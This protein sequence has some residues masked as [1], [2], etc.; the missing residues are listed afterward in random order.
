M[1]Y[2]LPV[3]VAFM[4]SFG[5]ANAEMAAPAPKAAAP[6]AKATTA[7][8][9]RTAKSLECSKEAD[10]KNLHGKPRKA[11]MSKCKKEK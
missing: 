10:T 2:L 6:A 7:K 3:C 11:F 8:K 9:E 5:V 4:M 1:K